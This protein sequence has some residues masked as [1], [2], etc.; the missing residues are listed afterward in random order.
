MEEMRLILGEN[1][2]RNGESGGLSKESYK[3]TRNHSSK[4]S[5]QRPGGFYLLYKV[6]DRLQNA[7]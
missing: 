1:C 2:K 7:C 4:G 3:S 5:L 6:Y